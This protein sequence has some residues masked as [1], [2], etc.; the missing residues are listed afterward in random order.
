M[1]SPGEVHPG[2][3]PPRGPG[4]A[5]RADCEHHKNFYFG[6]KSGNHQDLQLIFLGRLQR[7]D[8]QVLLYI[9]ILI[10]L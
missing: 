7:G 4:T 5:G 2:H 1:S 9:Y 8:S 6:R 3:L 10:I